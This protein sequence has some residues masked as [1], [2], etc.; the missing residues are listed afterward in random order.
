M[1]DNENVN[2]TENAV[3]VNETENTENEAVSADKSGTA[4]VK[5]R[6]ILNIV[7]DVVLYAFLVLCVFILI[8]SLASKKNDG[9]V[10]IFGTEMRVVVSESMS[11]SEY[12]VDVSGYKIKDIP[13]RSMVF[14]E[15]VPEDEAKAKEWY[16]KLEVG[17]VL[18]FRYRVAGATA[19]E[20]VTHRIT[21]ITPTQTGYIIYLQGDNRGSA[22]SNVNTQV[23]YTSK[24]D[25]PSNNENYRLGF[26]Y[27]I[28]KVT[29]QSVVLGNISYV[30]SKPVG[31]ACIIIVPCAIIIIW[32]IARVIIVLTGE[33][34][35]KAA[36]KLAEA[37]TKA[38]A[39]SAERERQAQELEE[40]KRK[41]AEL[42]GNKPKADGDSGV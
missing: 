15:R 21:E 7:L 12:S 30:L 29:G 18:T 40:L 31:L 2:E 13:L 14:V 38:A 36:E 4:G 23:I 37:E 27:V 3:D 28:G 33:R 39:E 32:Q 16:G 41:L 35:K 9:A 24:E 11:K 5:V 8:V 17:D 25:Y 20:T 22:D 26:N 19:Q 1:S 42:E 10:N 6:K 34:K